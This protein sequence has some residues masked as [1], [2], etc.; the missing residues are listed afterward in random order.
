MSQSKLE[1]PL[2]DVGIQV[3]KKEELIAPL[4]EN[5]IDDDLNGF[6]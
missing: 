2:L 1:Y 6:R 3:Q 4:R 5:I